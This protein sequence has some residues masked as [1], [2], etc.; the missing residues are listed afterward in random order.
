MENVQG[1]DL[2]LINGK[3]IT[4]QKSNKITEA[5]AVKGDKIVAVGSTHQIKDWIGPGTVVLDIKGKAVVPGFIESHCHPSI[6]GPGLVFELIVQDAKSIDDII[7]MISKRVQGMPKGR[8][9]IARRY[10]DQRLKERRHPTKWDLDRA[11]TDHPIFLRRA[12][13]GLSVANS[14]ALKLAGVTDQTPDPKGGK[15]DR[16]PQ[17]GQ[18]N[19]VMRLEA[20]TIVKKMMPSY[21]I[22]E[23]KEGILEACREFARFGITSFTDT[24][25][26]HGSLVAY[27]ELVEEGAL[28]LRAGVLIPWLPML[29]HPGYGTELKTLGIR[30]GF[31]NERLRIIGAKFSADGNM[32]TWTSALYEPYSNEPGNY[33]IIKGSKEELTAGIVEAHIAGLRPCVHAIGDRAIDMVLDAFEAASKIKPVEDARF[34][35]EKCTIPTPEAI[36]RIKH[37]GVIP[38]SLTGFLYELGPTHLLAIG[39]E[40]IKRYFPHKTY[41]EKGILSTSGSDW[42]VT[43]ANVAQQ[44]YGIVTRKTHSGEILGG[45]QA[46]SVM[47]ALSLYTM[48]AAYS[49]FEESI[50]GSIE[51]G[52]LAD[53]AVLDRDILT[54]PEEQLKDF[55]V[56]TTVVGGKIVYQKEKG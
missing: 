8:W 50:K 21:S 54:I 36:E 52:K 53:M 41:L 39:Q 5:V 23:I 12:D 18:L 35:I 4:M 6:G 3:I 17:S 56:E 37:L 15:F 26:T 48:N 44:I 38:S 10:D 28:F 42:S 31:G 9:I 51:T 55:K 14:L 13:Y 43:S 33:G 1:A 11:S 29:E 22:Q 19:G 30:T 20:Q 47:E 27:Q 25:V 46:I 49:S 16:D 34:R 24:I 40:R 2:V 32:S 7:E 45:E